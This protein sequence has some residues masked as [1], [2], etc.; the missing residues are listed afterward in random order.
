VHVPDGSFLSS[1]IPRLAAEL[2]P[3]W[4]VL[5]IS[6]RPSVPYQVTALD[7]VGVL[8]QLGCEHNLLVGEGTGCLTALLVA[9][10]YPPKVSGLLL[11]DGRYAGDRY[12]RECPPDLAA[13][14]AMVSCAVCEASSGDLHLAERVAAMLTLP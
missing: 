2:A 9:A 11:V 13:L 10:W 7:V 3:T 4:R 6:P 14:R 8:D 1:S 12:L 5:S